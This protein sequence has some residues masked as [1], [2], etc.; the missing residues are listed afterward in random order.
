MGCKPFQ[1]M[2]KKVNML[3]NR[4]MKA[5]HDEYCKNFIQT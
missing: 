4:V 5:T 3:I 2:F 1:Q